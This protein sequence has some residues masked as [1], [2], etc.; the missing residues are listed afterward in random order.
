MFPNPFRAQPHTRRALSDQ[1]RQE[2]RDFETWFKAQQSTMEKKCAEKFKEMDKDF[3]AKSSSSSAPTPAP[4]S[5]KRLT[6]AQKQQQQKEQEAQKK[7]QLQKQKEEQKGHDESK[8]AVRLSLRKSLVLSG[9]EEWQKRL[10]EKG[11][12][13]EDW[14]DMTEGEQMAVQRLLGGDFDEEEEE[15][16]D[17][18]DEEDSSLLHAM[19]QTQIQSLLRQAPLPSTSGQQPVAGSSKL[20]TPQHPQPSPQSL[21]ASLAALQTSVPAASSLPSASRSTNPTSLATSQ[22]TP[23]ASTNQPNN[24]GGSY[25]FVN[26]S[27]FGHPRVYED[28]DDDD[29]GSSPF[30][31]LTFFS[32]VLKQPAS[33]NPFPSH[34]A[35]SFHS[36][37]SSLSGWSTEFSLSSTATSTQTSH[38]GS[39]EQPAPKT[40]AADPMPGGWNFAGGKLDA[41]PTQATASGKKSGW[42]SSQT[43]TAQAGSAKQAGKQ[44]QRSVDS[45]ASTSSLSS[46]SGSGSG[47]GNAPASTNHNTTTTTSR[48]RV[49]GPPYIGPVLN[50]QED[51]ITYTNTHNTSSNNHH[52]H[53]NHNGNNAHSGGPV[54]VELTSEEAD[55]ENFKMDVRI[56]KIHEFHQEAAAADEALIRDIF[57][58]RKLH[59]LGLYDDQIEIPGAGGS[60]SGVGG[61][62]G[63]G[64]GNG[65]GGEGKGSEDETALLRRERERRCYEEENKKIVEH[66]KT[67]VHLRKLKEDE[68][69]EIVDDERR[70]RRNAIKRRSVVGPSHPQQQHQQEIASASSV[71]GHIKAASAPSSSSSSSAA[72][73]SK[74]ASSSSSSMGMGMGMGF[75][76]GTIRA[77][78]QSSA[79]ISASMLFPPQLDSALST[80]STSS[81]ASYAASAFFTPSSFTPSI[82]S[83]PLAS[84][85]SSMEDS[86]VD[87]FAFDEAKIASILAAQAQMA[88]KFDSWA[89][90]A[91]A[92]S[93]QNGSP[94]GPEET[95]PS[96]AAS[97]PAS[98]ATGVLSGKNASAA[99]TASSSLGDEKRSGNGK[100]KEGTTKAASARA[101]APAAPAPAVVAEPEPKPVV[102]NSKLSKAAKKKGK[103]GASA[104]EPPAPAPVAAKSN[105]K[106]DAKA[107]GKESVVAAKVVE[108]AKDAGS[109]GGFGGKV[110]VSKEALQQAPVPQPSVKSPWAKKEEP[111]VAKSKSDAGV[112]AGSGSQ[113]QSKVP[114]QKEPAA[115]RWKFSLFDDDEPMTATAGATSS[116]TTLDQAASAALSGLKSTLLQPPTQG[117]WMPGGNAGVARAS[118]DQPT[119][120]LKAPDVAGVLRTVSDQSSAKPSSA[121][122]QAQAHM[123]SRPEIWL[124]PKAKQTTG[125]IAQPQQQQSQQPWDRKPMSAAAR[126][127]RMSEPAPPSPVDPAFFAEPSVANGTRRAADAQGRTI[128]KKGTKASKKSGVMVEEVSDDEETEGMSEALPTDSRHIME[129]NPNIVKP[130][131][132]VPSKMFDNII[133]YDE[134][135]YDSGSTISG[136]STVGG[137][138]SLVGGMAESKS[139]KAKHVRWTPSALG[140]ASPISFRGDEEGPGMNI[141]AF[142]QDAASAL[143]QGKA[144]VPPTGGRGRT[145]SMSQGGGFKWGQANNRAGDVEGRTPGAPKQDNSDELGWYAM[146]AMKQMRSKPASAV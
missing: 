27:S 111:A 126:A 98:S 118:S 8:N 93:S 5:K 105:E 53:G 73:T 75:G 59:K 47:L 19:T 26:P 135:D 18:D 104:P 16:D 103:K 4:A 60:G 77:K 20:P 66:E 3:H 56:R 32:E 42:L 41:T 90:T 33:S 117:I 49:A 68:R 125:N 30:E 114:A 36:E 23:T 40:I 134:E 80:S 131:P 124:P 70:K 132:S 142:L 138:D 69:K 54:H 50:T 65:A 107:K 95:L 128:L 109:I 145:G 113:Q 99:S 136:P 39:P 87:E 85:S 62:G 52:N 119:G 61:N 34:P 64:S 57:R 44:P 83:V 120:G 35:S 51:Y 55:F 137:W 74:G 22:S 24:V 58:S 17:E 25:A 21:Q 81:N 130:K 9:R 141:E 2:W 82:S 11:L 115:A 28:D 89:P 139:T 97:A 37:S 144:G 29:G 116:R 101:P 38:T 7:A 43:Q 79:P 6:A 31:D 96:T 67:M 45:S 110:T 94:R 76:S 86:A 140:N 84:S 48:S 10:G 13:D 143:H 91:G 121:S 123:A 108:P 106:V 122:A 63:G 127:R 71:S 46:A 133:A 78:P 88:Q 92:G 12:Q 15:G 129:E 14:V 146:E 100:E 72:A 102:N 112:P 1:V